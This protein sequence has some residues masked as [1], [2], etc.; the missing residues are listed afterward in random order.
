MNTLQAKVWA[1]LLL[2]PLLS[3]AEVV[4]ENSITYV[5]TDLGTLPGDTTST[6]VGINALGQVTGVSNNDSGTTPHA[7]IYSNGVM[8]A[9]PTPAGFPYSAAL[10]INDAGQVVGTAYNSYDSYPTPPV[11]HGFIYSNGAVT[12]IGLLAG[13]SGWSTAASINNSGQVVG[14]WSSSPTGPGQ[15]FI[16]SHGV[17]TNLAALPGDSGSIGAAINASGQVTGTSINPGSNRAFI[18][19]NGVMTDI[20]RT[21]FESVATAINASGQVVGFEWGCCISTAPEHAFLYSNNVVTDLGTLTGDG[22]SYAEGINDLGQVT[23]YSASGAWRHAFLY[24]NGV[25]VD[26][27]S[28]INPALGIVIIDA[29]GIN[30]QGQIAATGFNAAGGEDAFL[31]TPAPEPSGLWL[32]GGALLALRIGRRREP[33]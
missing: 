30:D 7:F 13:A 26:L 20:S 11:T 32:A 3:Q 10:G 29:E 23:G 2:L 21:G 17:M 5:V 15:A 33:A 27:N 24:T 19:S 9:V 25:M 22:V 18:Y 28:L 4:T 31:L 1:F 8:A 14:T 12:D 6:G 16:Y